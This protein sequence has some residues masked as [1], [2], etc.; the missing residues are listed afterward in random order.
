M[1]KLQGLAD[2]L[3]A[4]LAPRAT[5]SAVWITECSCNPYPWNPGCGLS[6]RKVCRRCH[7]GSG[8]CTAWEFQYCGC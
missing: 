6:S 7:D 5:A 8:Q 4:R 3:V 1:R 2:A